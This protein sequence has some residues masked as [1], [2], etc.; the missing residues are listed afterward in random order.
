MKDGDD[1]KCKVSF[2]IRSSGLLILCE[3]KAHGP[4]D[5]HF[6]HTRGLPT[7]RLR[8]F[9]GTRASTGR[10]MGLTCT[11]ASRSRASMTQTQWLI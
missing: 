2:R 10:N 8:K 6:L 9:Q 5:S 7:R 3:V 11:T 4:Y 1:Q